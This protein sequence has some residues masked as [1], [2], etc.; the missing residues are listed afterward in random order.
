MSNEQIYFSDN[1]VSQVRQSFL[2]RLSQK[3]SKN[4][5]YAETKYDLQDM[6]RLVND[7]WFI[8]RFLVE[9]PSTTVA[10]AVRK[11]HDA[12]VWRNKFGV[13]QL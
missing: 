8:R 9:K 7:D 13:N 12:M 5:K 11:V 6:D 1:F 10:V 3:R 2:K 4:E